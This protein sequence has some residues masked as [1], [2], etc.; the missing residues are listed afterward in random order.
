MGERRG[1]WLQDFPSGRFFREW[2]GSRPECKDSEQGV[3]DSL[4]EEEEDGDEEKSEERGKGCQ[5]LTCP[6]FDYYPIYHM[7]GALWGK[8]PFWRESKSLKAGPTGVVTIIAFQSY[9]SQFCVCSF[10]VSGSHLV[11]GGVMGKDKVA[12]FPWWS[13]S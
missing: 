5:S 12:K 9:F 8:S 7:R 1:E 13:S 6:C 2:R 10:S 3:K 11:E 4:E